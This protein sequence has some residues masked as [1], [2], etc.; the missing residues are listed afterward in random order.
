M[1][2]YMCHSWRVLWTTDGEVWHERGFCTF[3]T[4][5]KFARD[6]TEENGCNP[7]FSFYAERMMTVNSTSFLDAESA[8]EVELAPHLLG[9]AETFA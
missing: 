8:G 1:G 2:D 3:Y 6:L 5:Q 4:A 9:T 7:A